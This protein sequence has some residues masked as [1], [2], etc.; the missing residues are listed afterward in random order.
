M[1]N[2]MDL[3]KS[4]KNY[5]WMAFMPMVIF[6]LLFVGCGVYFTIIGAEE[7]FG[8]M[9]RYVAVLI[10]IM[11]AFLFY[12]R[13]TPLD[14]KVN[15][16]TRGAGS[17]G[18]MLL[19]IIILL[20]G[21]FAEVTAAMGGKESIV[22]LGLTLIPANFLIPGIFLVS[23]VISTCIGTSMGTQVAMIPVAIAVAE[24]AGLNVG[25]AG[26][27]AIAGAYFGDN[28]SMISD[29]TI[30]ATKGVGA[31]MKDK[32]KMNFLIALPA[33]LITIVLYA[34]M[35][36]GGTGKELGDLSYNILEVLPY[37][38][39]LVTA[40]LG[41]NVIMVLCIGIG[42]ST[43]I[44]MAL[45]TVSFFDCAIAVSEGMQ[46]MFFLFVFASLVSGLI[47]LIKYYGG[48]EWLVTTLTEKIKSR[49]SC[50]KI[51]GL[52]AMA[53]SGTTL[54]NTVAIVITAP[55]AKELG[56]KYRIAPK[57][58]ASLLDIFS[59]AILGLVPHDSSIL[60][61]QQYGG[62]DYL[63]ILKYSFYP[64]LLIVATIITIQFGLLRTKEENEQVNQSP[65]VEIDA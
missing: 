22:N 42:M 15:V 14:K 23:S 64:V 38:T 24:G 41:L 3:L 18:V 5:K 43:L 29:T 7:P 28:L 48:I 46:S 12:D 2:E 31:E 61:V 21:G 26:A 58:L 59:C 34:T 1:E 16:Y 39:V 10:A 35:S 53:L 44:G 4:E 17:S 60:L 6:L 56:N 49:K 55:I 20:A 51:I 45:G 11:I 40:L 52:T 33:A 30:V 9:P 62:I 19:G 13:K 36:G 63:D 27:A 50:E 47:E 54:N 25:M 32:F 65:A 37:I 8:K 57:R